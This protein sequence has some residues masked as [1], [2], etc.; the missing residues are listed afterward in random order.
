METCW[1]LCFACELFEKQFQRE[2]EMPKYKMI[3]KLFFE[4]EII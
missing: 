1:V 3:I 2:E 4:S